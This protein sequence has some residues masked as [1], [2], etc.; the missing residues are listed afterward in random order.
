MLKKRLDE[1]SRQRVRAA[2]LLQKGKKPTEVALAVGVARQTAYRWKALLDESGI[3]ALRCMAAPGRPAR[4]EAWQLEG[5][6]RALLK[7][8]S[9]Y[10]FETELWTLKRVGALIHR[11]Y[12]VKFG[13]TN[14]WL[15]LGALGFSPQKPERRAIE[16]DDKAVRG[17]RRCTWPALQKKPGVRAG[18]SSSSTSRA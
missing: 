12:G 9:E 5:L 16:R 17:W 10:G 14:I 1:V 18:R 2:R 4:L 8:P 15:I 3:D 6:A 7:K 11:L 13:L